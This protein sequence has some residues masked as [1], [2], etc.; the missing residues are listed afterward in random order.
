MHIKPSMVDSC[1][2]EIETVW[3]CDNSR[4]PG[5]QADGRTGNSQEWA[6]A[7]ARA[8]WKKLDPWNILGPRILL[9]RQGLCC[10]ECLRYYQQV[11]ERCDKRTSREEIMRRRD[12]EIA[13]SSRSF[14]SFKHKLYIYIHTYIHIYIYIYLFIYI[15]IKVIKMHLRCG[16]SVLFFSVSSVITVCD[17]HSFWHI[18]PFIDSL[19]LGAPLP[20]NC[21]P[22]IGHAAGLKEALA[23]LEGEAL[24][25]WLG[26][27]SLHDGT[28]LW[29]T[30]LI[31]GSGGEQPRGFFPSAS[32]ILMGLLIVS[33]MFHAVGHLAP[34]QFDPQ[35]HHS[36]PCVVQV[37]G[38]EKG[39]RAGGVRVGGFVLVRLTA[40]FLGSSKLSLKPSRR[41][42]RTARFASGPRMSCHPGDLPW[43][44]VVPHDLQRYA[45]T[46]SSWD[47][48]LS[49]KTNHGLV[50]FTS[51]SLAEF[52]GYSCFRQISTVFYSGMGGVIECRH[53]IYHDMFLKR[54]LQ[55][56][57]GATSQTQQSRRR[58]PRATSFDPG[59]RWCNCRFRRWIARLVAAT[60]IARCPEFDIYLQCNPLW[61][62]RSTC[63]GRPT[64]RFLRNLAWTQAGPK[65]QPLRKC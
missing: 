52:T 21:D 15:H 24:V 39:R 49:F 44:L 63:T 29:L 34:C 1:F 14:K 18:L 10:V 43:I 20:H 25:P 61:Q 53:E 46:W 57:L 56:G 42:L 23:V 59:L 7:L 51:C 4:S 37:V 31:W 13:G 65:S 45:K 6:S 16:C 2:H 58:Q 5:A 22:A 47:T 30:S 40:W 48:R 36:R 41:Q 33:R 38:G 50:P 11:K 55:C 19:A 62:L 60:L 54:V 17:I 64:M 32:G 3:I 28:L 26:S 8:P 35:S 9:Q 27:K 12:Q